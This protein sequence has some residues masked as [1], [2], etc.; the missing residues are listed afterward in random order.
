MFLCSFFK[1]VNIYHGTKHGGSIFSY[2]V[3]IADYLLLKFRVF[4]CYESHAYKPATEEDYYNRVM[5]VV[6]SCWPF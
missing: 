4:F 6:S 5:H 3:F 1:D 2:Y